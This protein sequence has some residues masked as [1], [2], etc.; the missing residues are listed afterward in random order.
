MIKA[1]QDIR[2][3]CNKVLE[4]RM[5]NYDQNELPVN[6]HLEEFKNI[7]D[8]ATSKLFYKLKGEWVNQLISIIKTEFQGVGKGWFNMK[9]TSKV[10]YDFGK[11][12]RFLTVVRLVMQ[13]TLLSLMKLR[14]REFVDYFD[15]F[16]PQQV[17]IHSTSQIDNIFSD[18]SSKE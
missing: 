14:Q 9:E 4:L 8:A 5:Y 11:L 3:E 18:A 2:K 7:Q 13:D 15:S 6:M 16:I 1:L 17:I 10:T 12:K